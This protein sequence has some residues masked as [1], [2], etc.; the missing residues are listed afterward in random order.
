MFALSLVHLYMENQHELM[1]NTIYLTVSIEEGCVNRAWLELVDDHEE[2]LAEQ[3]SILYQDYDLEEDIVMSR[4][5]CRAMQCEVD[6]LE[7]VVDRIHYDIFIQRVHAFYLSFAIGLPD[8]R[9]P[10]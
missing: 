4:A 2:L 5:D 6:E 7:L 9:R 1:H 10:V 8:L 3:A